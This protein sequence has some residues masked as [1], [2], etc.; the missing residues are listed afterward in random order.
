MNVS[1][2]TANGI[3]I[4][5]RQGWNGIQAVCELLKAQVAHYQW[6]GIYWMNDA[7]Q[8]LYLGPYAGAATE[9]TRIP[10]GRG[11]CGQVAQSGT[12]FEVPDVWAQDN[13]LACSLETKSE[14]VVPIYCGTRLIGQI[15][16]DSH[17]VDPFSP[18]DHEL[19]EAL[20]NAIGAMP[21]AATIG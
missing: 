18:A 17:F 7:E 19:L 20:A 6:V 13:Y 15:D 10:Y 3:Q 16:I 9:H 11:I 8:A 2:L 21:E 12:S 4:L 14:L 1:E 5:E